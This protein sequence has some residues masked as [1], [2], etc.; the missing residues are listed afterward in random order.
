VIPIFEYR[1]DGGE[2][3]PFENASPGQQATALI[4]LLLGQ[5][6]GPLLIDQPEDDLDNTTILDVAE[7]VWGSKEKRQIIFSTHNPN[8]VVIGD[9]ELVIHCD[10]CQPGTSTRVQVSHQ[11]AIDN[12][13]ICEVITRVMEG[14]EEAFDLRKQKYGF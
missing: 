7:R 14:G 5:S 13:V 2:Y 10:Y 3:I 9:A 8:L 12:P 6:R 11:G 1:T 4:Q